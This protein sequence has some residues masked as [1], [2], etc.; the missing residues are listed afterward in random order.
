M[1]LLPLVLLSLAGFTPLSSGATLGARGMAFY[2]LTDDNR[3]VSFCDTAVTSP[4][5]PMAITGLA[6]NDS[7]V[8]IDVRPMNQ[9]LYGLARNSVTGV[10]T[11]YMISPESGIASLVGTPQ[12]PLVDPI[13]GG[14]VATA[15]ERYDIDFHPAA[16]R[17]RVVNSAGLNFR[18]NP[19]TGN[20]VDGN[21]TSDNGMNPDG[22]INGGTTSVDGAAYTNNDPLAT[23]T[24][25][26][27]FS[28]ATDRIYI[29]NIPN[30]GTQ[31]VPVSVSLPLGISA[32]R[33]F[34][35]APGVNAPMNNAPASGQAYAIL[36]NGLGFTNL[37]RVNL[38][39][40]SIS[41]MGE[42]TG[43]NPRSL[44]IRTQIPAAIGLSE[45]GTTLIRFRTT[46]PS[47]EVAQ[48]IGTQNLAAGE[49]LVGID[50]R[51]SNGQLLGFA[52]NDAANTGT[53]YNVDPKTGELKPVGARGQV[54][55]VGSDGFTSVDFPAASTGYGFD[56]D[57]VTDR[58]RVV[59]YS[60]LN[61]R[62]NP[63]NGAPSDGN[64]GLAGAITGTNPDGILSGGTTHGTS[65]A[66]TNSYNNP[67]GQTTLYNLDPLGNSMWIQH[68][69]N[70]G[71]Q[72]EQKV[73]RVGAT[74]LNF[75]AASGFDITAEGGT[76]GLAGTPSRGHGWAAL[77]VE[78][79]TRLYQ[80]DLSTGQAIHKGAIALGGSLS[81][82]VVASENGAGHA[83]MSWPSIPGTAYRIE[84]SVDLLNWKPYAYKITANGTVTT[85]PVP[86]YQGEA[87]RFW[88]A[89]NP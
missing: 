63:S 59:T 86:L 74:E 21:F 14:Q 52:V 82:L 69:P 65:L 40:G 16:D 88:R 4:S 18:M 72:L 61:F 53:L 77:R 58:A 42:L 84:T 87:R 13:S 31:T 71:S 22:P 10:L 46:S 25:L 23:V 12:E 44:A 17:L 67:S 8:A 56:I 9:Q 34:D 75:T 80:I 83:P 19:N 39:T 64:L 41:F 37:Y 55:Y 50:F 27:T 30:D 26:Y 35:I 20:Y 68:P 78:G 11:L 7:L 1:R 47:L 24:T 62:I 81:S 28:S 15:A 73:L 45:D 38:G 54:A 89:V 76:S 29:Q 85:V 43:Y 49:T 79:V 36:S 51:P 57:P 33:G 3:L 48:S 66:Y 2:V 60:G 32:V 70:S 5:P 6:T